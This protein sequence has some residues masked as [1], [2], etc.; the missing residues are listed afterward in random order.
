MNRKNGMISLHLKDRRNY[1]RKK[2]VQEQSLKKRRLV[3]M[4]LVHV[5]QERNINIVVE[6]NL[7][8]SEKR[9]QNLY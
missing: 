5:V 7:R 1:T 8:L 2:N 6:D 4:I 3:E 9:R